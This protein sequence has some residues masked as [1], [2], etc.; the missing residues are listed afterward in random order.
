MSDTRFPKL[1]L[2]AQ[3]SRSTAA[4]NR[5]NQTAVGYKPRSDRKYLAEDNLEDPLQHADLDPNLETPMAQGDVK[6]KQHRNT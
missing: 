4:A 3:I 1:E 6:Y 2:L 5:Y